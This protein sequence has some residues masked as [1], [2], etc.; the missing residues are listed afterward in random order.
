MMDDW[1][2]IL[3]QAVRVALFLAM[4]GGTLGLGLRV[5]GPS[6][7]LFSQID[8]PRLGG[9]DILGWY[10]AGL[11]RGAWHGATWGFLLGGLWGLLRHWWER[12]M[13]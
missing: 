3:T 13:G 5:F 6:E 12:R 1:R 4:A 7:S 2:T 10:L 11:W 9:T 8:A